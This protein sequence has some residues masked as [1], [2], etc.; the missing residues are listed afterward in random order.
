MTI[1]SKAEMETALQCRF[2]RLYSTRTPV[3]PGNAGAGFTISYWYQTAGFPS[4]GLAPSGTATALSNASTGAIAFMQQTSP[5]TSYLGDL[6]ASCPLAGHTVEIH[7]RLI[8]ITSTAQTTTQTVT[9]F[10][11]NSFLSTNNIGTRIGDANYS[12]VQWWVEN[13]L[14]GVNTTITLTINVTYNDGTTGNLTLAG[15]LNFRQARM[16]ALN[17]LIPAADAGKFIR[18]INNVT[19]S[20]TISP[21]NIAFV[22]TRYRASLYLEVANQ[23]YNGGWTELGMPEI[24]NQSCLFPIIIAPGVNVSTVN[25][26]GTIVHG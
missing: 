20:A 6:N 9:G 22:A 13:P 11:L 21:N 14:A 26:D 4:A 18:A 2:S 15:Y 1:A 24:Y 5:R 8:Q 17:S 3:N 12:D 10:A 7:D 25:L 19:S 23:I 16:F